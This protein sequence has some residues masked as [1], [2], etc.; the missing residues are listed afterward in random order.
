MRKWNESFTVVE[1]V[2]RT[3]TYLVDAVDPLV[4]FEGFH[5]LV[6]AAS[7]G[8]TLKPTRV[9]MIDEGIVADSSTWHSRDVGSLEP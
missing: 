1:T 9:F 2:I 5:H 3:A 7:D 6:R 4:V 8:E